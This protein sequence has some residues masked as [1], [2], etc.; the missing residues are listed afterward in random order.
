[1]SRC[2]Q[3]LK[4]DV[5]LTAALLLALLSCLLVT[6]D[7]HYIGYIDFGT[8]ILLFC[9]MLVVEN[10]RARIRALVPLI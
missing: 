2:I 6:P 7:S 10:L 4:K 1:M 8:L 9:L 3:Y 5:I